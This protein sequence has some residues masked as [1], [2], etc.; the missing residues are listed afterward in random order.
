[1]WKAVNI[2]NAACFENHHF[3]GILKTCGRDKTCNVPYLSIIF[4]MV[5]LGAGKGFARFLIG[6][7]GWMNPQQLSQ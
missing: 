5:F 6:C 7:G 1:M 4:D 3:G 2:T